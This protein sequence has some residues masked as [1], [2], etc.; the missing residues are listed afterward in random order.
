MLVFGSKLTSKFW[1]FSNQ[2]SLSLSLFSGW[3]RRSRWSCGTKWRYLWGESGTAS[4]YVFEFAKAVSSPFTLPSMVLL[5]DILSYVSVL[6]LHYRVLA[7]LAMHIDRSE[8]FSRIILHRIIVILYF[9]LIW[10][11]HLCMLSICFGLWWIVK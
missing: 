4:L 2:Y 10:L 5:L 7:K 6:I 11:L 8:L 3:K 1:I 9:W